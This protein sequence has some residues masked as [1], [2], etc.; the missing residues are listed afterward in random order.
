MAGRLPK[1][2]SPGP[3]DML[4]KGIKT[5]IGICVQRLARRTIPAWQ[6]ALVTALNVVLRT[7]S[8]QKAQ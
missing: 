5:G 6:T 1:T 4:F 8:R 3:G 7:A 2:R